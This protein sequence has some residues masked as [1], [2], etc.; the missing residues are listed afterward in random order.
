[1]GET[2]IIPDIERGPRSLSLDVYDTEWLSDF[3]PDI[4]ENF[5]LLM[6]DLNELLVA[7]SIHA[8]NVSPF[9]KAMIRG[10]RERFYRTIGFDD[11]ELERLKEIYPS[12]TPVD[13]FVSSQRVYYA[14]GIPGSRVIKTMPQLL[15]YAG[16]AVAE[17]MEVLTT[18]G[19]DIR[20]AVSKYPNILTLAPGSLRQKLQTMSQLGFD[21]AKIGR[22]WPSGLGHSMDQIRSRLDAFEQ[23][24]IDGAKAINT[25]PN[26]MSISVDSIGHKIEDLGRMGLDAIQVI[27]THP[28][29]LALPSEKLFDRMK[30]LEKIGVKPEHISRQP[31]LLGYDPEKIAKKID[32]LQ[33]LEGV[34]EWK[35]DTN[36]LIDAY[37]AVL[38]FDR[39]KLG[40]L[41]RIVAETGA[42]ED[43]QLEPAQLATFMRI[44][45]ET[46][47][48]N[49]SKK[50]DISG[51][52]NLYREA[53]KIK[54]T[55]IERRE[56]ALHLSS[57]NRLG[58]LGMSYLAYRS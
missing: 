33:R 29:L 21:V 37:P 31:S 13:T 11:E 4:A 50:P 16:A 46:Y 48:I 1:M 30:E 24:G 27:R 42:Q 5:P 20:Y 17:R 56:E 47:L 39:K 49:I 7:G 51:L 14:N 15:Y 19:I 32:Y 43:R 2:L 9:D 22:V 45:V 26:I 55:Q 8:D 40:L 36:D 23:V 53:R 41:A 25:A 18:E 44:P 28:N 10:A 54:I 3:N 12:L 58:R 38:A 34:L 52:M 6:D 57:T 35:H